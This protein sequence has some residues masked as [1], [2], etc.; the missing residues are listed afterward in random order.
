MEIDVMSTWN[1]SRDNFDPKPFSTNHLITLMLF[2]SME[3]SINSYKSILSK[4][5]K[6]TTLTNANLTGSFAIKLSFCFICSIT[7]F[8]HLLFEAINSNCQAKD[9]NSIS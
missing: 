8:P 4:K 6:S 3:F 9:K 7:C 5:K 2:I 1:D